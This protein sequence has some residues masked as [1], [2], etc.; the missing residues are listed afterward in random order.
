MLSFEVL[1]ELYT[2]LSRDRFRRYIDEED[3]RH[4][5][6]ALVREAERVEVGTQ[7]LACRDSK[8]DKFLSL[9]V[10]GGATHIVSGDADLLVHN[11][12]Q[13]VEIITPDEF[14]KL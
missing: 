12:F 2:V 1:S 10:D 9:A 4:F 3:I 14:L 5:L 11:P 6:A 13:G 8:D 7:V